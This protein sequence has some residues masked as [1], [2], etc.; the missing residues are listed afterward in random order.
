MLPIT[1]K[2]APT[3]R[4]YMVVCVTFQTKAEAQDHPSDTLWHVIATRNDYQGWV[5]TAINTSMTAGVPH[6]RLQSKQATLPA[7]LITLNDLL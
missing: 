4:E 3:Q 1:R 5:K 6:P 7:M 2:A